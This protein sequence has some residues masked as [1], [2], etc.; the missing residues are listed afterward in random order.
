MDLKPYREAE[1]GKRRRQITHMYNRARYQVRCFFL[2]HWNARSLETK[3]E[4]A[5][6]YAFP[7]HPELDF[8]QRFEAGEVKSIKRADCREYGTEVPWN[9]FSELDRSLQPDLLEI[10]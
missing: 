5:I 6:T 9:K 1:L 10:L 8:W 7:V 4:D 3:Q 2:I